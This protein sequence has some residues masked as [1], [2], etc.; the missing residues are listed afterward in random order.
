[1]K[2]AFVLTTLLAGASAFG[3]FIIYSFE[4]VR[5]IPVKTSFRNRLI[6]VIGTTSGHANG[7]GGR[8]DRTARCWQR[9]VWHFW[10]L[11]TLVVLTPRL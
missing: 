1:M 4:C 3:M 6:T 10:T 9:A 11:N 7:S 5:L 8:Q 2:T